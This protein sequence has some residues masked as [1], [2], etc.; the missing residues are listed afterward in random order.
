MYLRQS[1]IMNH[2]SAESLGIYLLNISFVVG[3]T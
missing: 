3:V 1:S 2:F